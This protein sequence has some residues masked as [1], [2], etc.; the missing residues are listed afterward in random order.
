MSQ[1]DF[2]TIDPVTKTGTVLASDLNMSRDAWHSNHLGIGAPSYIAEGMMWIDQDG[3]TPTDWTVNI[4]DGTQD[5]ALFTLDASAHTASLAVNTIDVSGNVGMGGNLSLTTNSA[6]ITLT[7]SVNDSIINAQGG[8]I[9][10][11]GFSGT[12]FQTNG[13]SRLIVQATSVRPNDLLGLLGLGTD[14]NRWGSS[15]FK[16]AMTIA[17]SWDFGANPI[18]TDADNFGILHDTAKV[19]MTIGGGSSSNCYIYFG[20]T[21]SL[22]RG[23]IIYLNDATTDNFTFYSGGTM[24]FMVNSGVTALAFATDGHAT[25]EDDVTINEN[26]IVTNEIALGGGSPQS[27]IALYIT[28]LSTGAGTTETVRLYATQDDDDLYTRY[29]HIGTT[30]TNWS[31]GYDYSGEG[32][33]I[34]E[35]ST[36]QSAGTATLFLSNTTDTATFA[37]D[38]ISGALKRIVA[39]GDTTNTTLTN[40]YLISAAIGVSGRM[41]LRDLSSGFTTGTSAKDGTA[42]ISD[43]GLFQIKGSKS[44]GSGSTATFFQLDQSSGNIEMGGTVPTSINS[45]SDNLVVSTATH[46]GMTLA[47]INPAATLNFYFAEGADNNIAQVSMRGSTHDDAGRMT[48]G[49]SVASG[50]EILFTTG[51]GLISMHMDSSQ[52]VWVGFND[53]QRGILRVSGGTTTDGGI[54][55]WMNGATDSGT[56]NYWRAQSQG[57]NFEIGPNTDTNAFTFTN[58][59]TLF[60]AGNLNANG[61]GII[62]GV[63]NSVSGNLTLHGLGSGIEGG[64]IDILGATASFAHWIIDSRNDELR[65]IVVETQDVNIGMFNAGAGAFNLDIGSGAIVLSD[66]G[67]ID[68]TGDLLMN[69]GEG[70]GIQRSNSVGIHGLLTQGDMT[71]KRSGITFSTSNELRFFTGSNVLAATLESGGDL[72]LVGEFERGSGTILNG[73]WDTFGDNM[74]SFGTHPRFVLQGTTS[75]AIV[76]IDSGN[77]LNQRV[78]TFNLQDGLFTF[79]KFSDNGGVAT[80]LMRFNMSTNAITMLLPTS[81][82]VSGTLWNDGGT[83]KVA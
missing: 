73:V 13:T 29:R 36:L 83:V 75:S 63:S 14:T 24:D 47:T 60:T 23:R 57:V 1:S 5:V 38:I 44:D 8:F 69:A 67:N 62:A 30:G 70:I 55:D 21:D 7:D 40:Y 77:T 72:T 52:Q 45:L 6:T 9:Y 80:E 53:F 15:F 66:T 18:H 46:V 10:M 41:Y 43:D 20:D 27:G 3:G 12:I 33:C 25:F 59:G 78:M 11:N 37:G 31:V 81:A 56:V 82:G 50:G 79:E 28:N 61:G 76:M 71:T 22:T 35:S 34:T 74:N 64:Q 4:Y 65:M 17:P 51:N 49:T 19:G 26:L 32:F 54:I 48:I 68:M 42:L 16:G 2:G 39:G 58:T